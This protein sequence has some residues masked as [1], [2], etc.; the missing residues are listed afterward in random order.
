MCAPSLDEACTMPS[1]FYK[2][3]TK[4]LHSR[5]YGITLA[6]KHFILRCD[7][8]HVTCLLTQFLHTCLWMIY[9]DLYSYKLLF[10]NII[11]VFVYLLHKVIIVKY[12][13]LWEMFY[14]AIMNKGICTKS[15][16]F[17]GRGVT[18]IAPSPH[19][20]HHMVTATSTTT[21]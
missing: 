10:S 4:M 9:K 8:K 16:F 21:T 19:T 1:H 18:K 2:S 12:H 11:L 3:V 14:M 15:G 13:L 6:M 17:W 7:I 20:P 5:C